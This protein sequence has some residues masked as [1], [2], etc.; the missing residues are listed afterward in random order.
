MTALAANGVI[1]IDIDE[2]PVGSTVFIAGA[3]FSSSANY[4]IRFDTTSVGTGAADAAG[5][6]STQFAVPSIARGQYP[7]KV[8]SVSDNSNIR[9]FT[10]TPEIRLNATSGRSGSQITVSGAGFKASSSISIYFDAASVATI[11]TSAAGAFAATT[12]TVPQTSAG[13]HSI[14]GRDSLG[15]SPEIVFSTQDPAIS[16]SRTTGHVG[17]EIR[18][19]GSGFKASTSVTILFDTTTV[20]TITADTAGKFANISVIIPSAAPGKHTISAKDT[21]GAAPGLEFTML[22]PEISLNQNSG[23]VGDQFLV[24]GFGFQANSAITIMFDGV[25][26]GTVTSGTTGA[27]SN[28][29]IIVPDT[30]GGTHTITARGTTDTS[31][32][33]T[34]QVL[35]GVAASPPSG[36]VGDNINISGAGFERNSSVTLIVTDDLSIDAAVNADGTFATAIKIPPMGAGEHIIKVRSA[37]GDE[38]AVKFSVNR[39][40]AVTPDTGPANAVVTVTGT[41]FAASDVIT[42][43]YNGIAV[44]TNPEEARADSRGNFSANFAV[45]SFLPGS[46]IVEAADSGS[47]ASANFNSILSASISP[48]TSLSE[49]GHV[50]MELTITGAGFQPNAK[51]IVT[52]AS[53]QKMLSNTISD[54]GGLF[55]ASF[56]VPPSP[57]G[58]HTV[59][60]TDGINTREFDFYLE[61]EAPPVPVLLLPETE[62]KSAQPVVFNWKDVDD[63][64]GVTY[65]LEI[66]DDERFENIVFKEDGLTEPEFAMPEDKLEPATLDNPYY[67]RVKAI[68]LA[69]NESDWS[70]TRTFSLGFILTLPNGE[71]VWSISAW[72]VYGGALAILAALIL[73]FWVGRRTVY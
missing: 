23:R 37:K 41:G 49:P 11:T 10:V 27:F 48:A 40:L 34:F 32:A 60:V 19:S 24:S 6:F 71:P 18:V 54:S 39:K 66:S 29:A 30:A 26:A 50:G 64:S 73:A 14:F 2:G 7:V 44:E 46:Y 22:Q 35:S 42:V 47:S 28:A 72:W 45:P 53:I 21:V 65:A 8:N 58:K 16:I 56:V 33:L 3:G 51:V 17:E 69:S 59:I 1:T 15:D 4:T 9:F 63:V 5:T 52:R 67:W 20:G 68:D 61:E 31:L 13:A 55:R 43:K 25:S 62:K 12:I 38:F 70:D 36:I 57:A